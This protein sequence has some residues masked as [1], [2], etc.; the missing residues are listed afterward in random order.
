MNAGR[1]LLVDK[2]VGPTSH[3]VVSRARRALGERRIGHTG[4]LDPFASG[5]VVLCVGPATRLAEYVSGVAKTYEATLR[6]GVATSTL[7]PEGEVDRECPVPDPLDPAGIEAVLDR[8]RGDIL[9]RPPAFSAKKQGGERAYE[10]ARRGEIV[11]LEPVPVTVHA[12]EV[13]RVASPEIDFRTTVSSGTYVR[14]LG[15]EIAE[16]LGSC[17]H[18]T[19][20]RRTAVGSLPVSAAIPLGDLIDWAGSPPES[21]PAFVDPLDAL[22]S[23]PSVDLAPDAVTDLAHGRAVAWDG[24]PADLALARSGADLLAV[25]RAEDGAFH[26]RKVFV[27]PEDLA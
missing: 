11:E 8:F 2:P 24:A 16:A 18:L 4:T 5:L 23:L 26:P 12:L 19:A 15:A 3:D 22:G 25:G 10:K 21:H 20:L 14:S 27:R 6:L 13:E 17:G 7:D 9:Q 1:F